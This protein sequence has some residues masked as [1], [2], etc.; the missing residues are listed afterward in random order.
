MEGDQWEQ[1]IVSEHLHDLPSLFL[2]RVQGTATGEGRL[3]KINDFGTFAAKT[4]FKVVVIQTSGLFSDTPDAE[5]RKTALCAEPAFPTDAQYT[6]THVVCV[7]LNADKGHYDLGAL[8][9]GDRVQVVFEIGEEWEAAETML[10]AFMKSHAPAR[11]AKWDWLE[12]RWQPLSERS[13]RAR[14][15]E[16]KSEEQR[17]G[18]S[19]KQKQQQSGKECSSLLSSS[20]SPLS[21]VGGGGGGGSRVHNTRRRQTRTAV[22]RHYS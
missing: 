11:G 21:V 6:K 12:P 3:G 8:R 16:S 9:R 14:R 18:G 10:L 15:S 2:P 7:M 5:F 20:P 19:K 13:K 22:A 17:E 1:L 4:H